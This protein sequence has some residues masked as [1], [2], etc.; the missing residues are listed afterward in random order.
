[1]CFRSIVL[2]LAIIVF[3]TPQGMAQVPNWYHA[4][5]SEASPFN[6]NTDYTYKHVLKNRQGAPVVVAIIDS[7]VDVEHEDLKDV[8][9]VNTD[10]I[11]SNGI[12]DDKNGY[13]DDINGWNFIGGSDGRH[14]DGDTFE[15]TRLYSKLDKK[16]ADVDESS[17]NKKAKEEYEKYKKYKK[18]IER[19]R[20]QNKVK[21]EEFKES[22][23]LYN[24]VIVRLSTIAGNEPLSTELANEL[25]ESS[26]RMD[27]LGA[28]IMHFFSNEL[29][30]MPNIDELT[31]LL[32]EP[33]RE[34]R[35]Y[36]EAR[37]KYNYNKDFDSREIVG[38]DYSNVNERFYGNNLVEGPD[39]EHGTHVAGIIGAERDNE[40]GINGIA[41]NV[42]LMAI[43]AVP[44]GDE[45][46]KDIANAIMY[47]VDNGAS[48]INMSFGKGFSPEKQAVDDAVRHA[49]KHD[50]LIVHAAGNGS[51]D[52]DASSNY[53]NDYFLKPKGFL[54]WKKKQPD[55]WISVGATSN[56]A[57]EDLV[58]SFS[59]Y[60]QKDVDIFAPGEYMYSTIPNDK[61]KYSQGT[62]MA[63]P[64]VSGVA[65]I[66]RS[67]FPTLT[68]KQ[69][70]EV[71]M[72]SAT[73]IDVEVKK[74]GSDELIPFNELSV[75]GG[76][77]DISRAVEIAKQTK[78][79]K[80]LKRVNTRP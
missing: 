37:Y 55:N 32:I 79:K 4:N 1:M 74:P 78:G 5:K 3:I 66:L 44:N 36:Y 40:L 47:A 49:E 53:P 18:D 38:D 17:L 57:G 7:G 56:A 63:A 50:V 24:A 64:I 28:N 21:Y 80:K 25:Q 15:Q 72:G 51:D 77:I 35:K 9:W 11:P 12:D 61:Y 2:Y 54:F 52:L 59:N 34:G 16:Y 69:V 75:S 73:P 23:D 62:S 19:Q 22:E 20:K 76:I 65:A 42:R 10:E 70:K 26:D 8:I 60:G 67:Y 43:R 31:A 6:I 41:E 45:R 30:Y 68:A 14:V 71:L 46:D 27:R 13:I 58:A 48:I 29:G 39:A 33:V